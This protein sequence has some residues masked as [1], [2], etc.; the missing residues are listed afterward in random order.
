MDIEL[1]VARKPAP[2]V[3]S[4]VCAMCSRP[5]KSSP[6]SRQPLRPPICDGCATHWGAS[7]RPA[8]LTRGD[9]AVLRRLSAITNRLEWEAING[10]H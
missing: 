9:H 4:F 3:D 10:R 7:F 1:M 5:Q 2:P 8:G 6:W